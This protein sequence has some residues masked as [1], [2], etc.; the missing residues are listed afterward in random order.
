MSATNSR[1]PQHIARAL[2]DRIVA[3]LAPF[4]ERIEIAGSL[5]RN[6]PNVGDIDL[7]VLPKSGMAEAM[8]QR[9]KRN[10]AVEI[11][12][13]QNLVVVLKNG[14]Q[15]DTFIARHAEADL[16]GDVTPC[17]WATLLL[18]R[19]GSKEHNIKLAQTALRNGDRWD[20]YAGVVKNGKALPADSESDIFEQL[21]LA[22]VPPARRE[23]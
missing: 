22:Y 15:V 5:R 3:E 10:A 17:N 19:T 8:R 7:V 12:G 18:C 9:I 4:C 11:D 6:L 23:A 16:L 2:A 1:W 21:G 20:P 13:A 14:L